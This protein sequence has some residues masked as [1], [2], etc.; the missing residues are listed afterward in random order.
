MSSFQKVIKYGAITFAILL[1]VGIISAI[2]STAVSVISFF[3]GNF[4]YS[5]NGKDIATVD[6]K[7][8]FT[9]VRSLDI[10]IATGNLTITEGDRFLVEADNVSED[11]EMKVTKNGTLIVRER[12]KGF[13]FL[14]FNFNLKKDFNSNITLYVPTNYQLEEAA[15][16]SGAGKV[17]MENFRAEKLTIDAGAGNIKGNNLSSSEVNLDGGAGS[18]TFIDVVFEDMDLNCGV[19]NVEIDGVLLGNNIIDCG[20]GN[21]ELEIDSHEEDYDLDIDSGLGKVRL[22]GKRISKDYRRDNDASSSIEIDGGI[23]NIDINFAR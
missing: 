4:F 21:V 19:G 23:G 1:T 2:A 10:D 13:H 15:I 7:E 8:N 18:V 9:D 6:E 14:W 16:S 5:S 11:F 20:I 22:N 12:K 3:T 17:S